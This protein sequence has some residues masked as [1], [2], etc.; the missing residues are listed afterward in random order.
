[1][2]A[3][4][5]LE[6]GAA[7]VAVLFFLHAA[8]GQNPPPPPTAIGANGTPLTPQQLDDLVAP[9]ALYPDPL[10][11]EVLAA[12]TYPLEIVEAQQWVQDH[13]QWKP[14]KL[15]DEAKKQNWDPSVQGLVAFPQVLAR[16]TQ[17]VG[18]TTALGNAFLA[19]QAD[20]MQAVQRMR[21]QAGAWHTSFRSSGDRNDA[22]SERA[23]GHR[24]STLR[25]GCL[26]RPRL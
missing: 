7:A 20:V 3:I 4:R 14:S 17:D 22:K 23:N 8:V 6:A 15:M 13:R 5:N 19:S 10:V 12:S 16:L 2:L 9:I 25:S 21:A 26:V 24:Y 18:W 11:G 1:M